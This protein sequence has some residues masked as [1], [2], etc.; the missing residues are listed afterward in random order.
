MQSPWIFATC[1]ERCKKILS[2][3]VQRGSVEGALTGGVCRHSVKVPMRDEFGHTSLDI[4]VDWSSHTIMPFVMAF[5]KWQ[6]NRVCLGV[7]KFCLEGLLVGRS[8]TCRRKREMCQ[9]E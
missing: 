8:R 5:F 3:M 9:N 6:W 4:R 7:D 2:P 1:K